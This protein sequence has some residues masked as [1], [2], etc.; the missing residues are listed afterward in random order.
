MCAVKKL[1]NELLRRTQ[2]GV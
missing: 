2:P 1:L